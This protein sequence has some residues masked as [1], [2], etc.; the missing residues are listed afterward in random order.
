V[1]TSAATLLT[2]ILYIEPG[3]HAMETCARAAI[4]EVQPELLLGILP[5]EGAIAHC[6]VH[7]RAQVTQLYA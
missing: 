1:Q 6:S 2:A 7:P 4:K 5:R 3:E